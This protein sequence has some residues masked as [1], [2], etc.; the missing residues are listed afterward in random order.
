M[1]IF[2]RPLGVL[3]LALLGGPAIFTAAAQDL[4]EDFTQARQHADNGQLHKALAIY[5]SLAANHPDNAEYL[6]ELGRTQLGLKRALA[7]TW[8]L[9]DAIAADPQ[10]EEA[11]R[12]LL[13]A[14][15]ESG[16]SERA[17]GILQEARERFGDRPWMED[18]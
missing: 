6:T 17:Y 3:M 7:A 13:K 4:A 9:K 11:Y 8:S 1:Y 2:F 10:R 14:Y 5:E 12:L 18:P 15:F 16:Q